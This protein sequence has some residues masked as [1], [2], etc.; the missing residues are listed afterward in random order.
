MTEVVIRYQLHPSLVFESLL[1]KPAMHNLSRR[2]HLHR[3]SIA[4]HTCVRKHVL[5]SSEA[6]TGPGGAALSMGGAKSKFRDS[7]SRRSQPI[8]SE[9]TLYNSQSYTEAP[10]SPTIHHHIPAPPAPWIPPPPPSS[11]TSDSVCVTAHLRLDANYTP[12]PRRA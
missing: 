7:R 5:C 6:D 1:A 4:P 3:K 12:N 9:S 2:M 11:T 10:H 8:L